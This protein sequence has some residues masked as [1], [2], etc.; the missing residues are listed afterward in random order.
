MFQC[1]DTR[2]CV[3][4]FWPSEDEHMCL[5]HVEAWNKLIVKQKFCASSWLITEM[6]GQ[7]N[8]KI[9]II[10]TLSIILNF[11]KHMIWEAE[12]VSVFTWN[13][14][15]K[16]PIVTHTDPLRVAVLV[17]IY[18]HQKCSSKTMCRRSEQFVQVH[19]V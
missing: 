7:Q 3:M 13:K 15:G 17:W 1:D 2:G 5:K 6:H 18:R 11:F 19:S 8:V 12:A 10:T 16:L 14:E 9:S 4:Q